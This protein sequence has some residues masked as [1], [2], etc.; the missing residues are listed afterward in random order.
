MTQKWKAFHI[1]KNTGQN[2]PVFLP[3]YL[4]SKLLPQQQPRKRSYRPWG[5]D[6]SAACGGKSDL[7]EWL[8][9]ADVEAA[10]SA[11][12]LPGT[13]TGGAISYIATQMPQ[14]A[15]SRLPHYHGRPKKGA[16]KKVPLIKLF[17]YSTNFISKNIS[18]NTR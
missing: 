17:Y 7:S 1:C 3:F 16:V 11:R 8:R 10:P 6:G 18:L 9:S 12:K 15:K 13:A 4:T 2:C 14:P 5:S